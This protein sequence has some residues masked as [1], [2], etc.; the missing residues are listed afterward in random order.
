MLLFF[1]NLLV[2]SK[3]KIVVM[4]IINANE[5]QLHIQTSKVR[6]ASI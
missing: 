6:L 2:K 3:S 1:L 5:K 4:K